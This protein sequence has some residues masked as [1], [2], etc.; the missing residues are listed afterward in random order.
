MIPLVSCSFSY[1]LYRLVLVVNV[2]GL[3]APLSWL[4]SILMLARWIGPVAEMTLLSCVWWLVE[5]VLQCLGG[6]SIDSG[7]AA[8]RKDGVAAFVSRL[9]ETVSWGSLGLVEEG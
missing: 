4:V 5:L 9:P 8:V 7:V 3:V 2:G 1:S 6:S